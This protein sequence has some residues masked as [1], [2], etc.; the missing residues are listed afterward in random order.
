MPRISDSIPINNP[1]L[2]RRVK[3]Q[4]EQ[5]KEIL[6]KGAG[7]GIRK[8]AREYGV[9]KRLIQFIFYPERITAS[10]KNRDWRRYYTKESNATSQREHRH[11]KSQ[12]YKAGL[13]VKR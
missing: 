6:T 7:Y 5:K 3:L 12:L 1:K 13:L 8:L 9:D 2:D 11:Y 10:R 4:P